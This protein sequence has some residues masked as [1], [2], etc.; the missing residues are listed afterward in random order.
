MNNER[1]EKLEQKKRKGFQFMDDRM[2]LKA[3]QLK[4]DRA[5]GIRTGIIMTF[6]SNSN[7]ALAIDYRR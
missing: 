5:G 6:S 4:R 1:F 7:P 3:I 2:P